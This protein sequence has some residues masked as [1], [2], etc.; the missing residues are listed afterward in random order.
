MYNDFKNRNPIGHLQ[1]MIG[2]QFVFLKLIKGK[3]QAFILPFLGDLGQWQ[4]NRRRE[5]APLHKNVS[6]KNKK[7]MPE[8]EY[9][10]FNGFRQ[11]ALTAAHIT[12]RERP[13]DFVCCL[14]KDIDTNYGITKGIGPESHPASRS[15]CQFARNTKEYVELYREYQS[16]KPDCENS[17][18]QTPQVFDSKLS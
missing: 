18:G 16:A 3:S 12:K 15:S 2:I 4:P 5:N 6:T 13:S 9:H 17:I 10:H 11:C 7:E 8:L 14:M 1:K